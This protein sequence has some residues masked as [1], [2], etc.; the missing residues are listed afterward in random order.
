MPVVA[1]STPVA[2]STL[3]KGARIALKYRTP[4]FVLSD[5]YLA[6]GSGPWLL[7]D[8]ESLPEISVDFVEQP[9]VDGGFMPY[10]R[11]PETLARQWAIQERPGSSTDRRAREGGRDRQR[12]L[13]PRQP[14]P[15]G[16]PARAEGGRDRR[17]HSRA[18]GRRPRRGVAARPGLG[19]DVR[20]PIQSAAQRL[21]K[22]GKQ[23]AH[24]HLTHLNPFPRNLGEVL[25]R[26]DR[27]L[28]PEMN[29]GQLLKLIRAEFLVDAVGYNRVRGSRSARMSS[30]RRSRRCS[31][32]RKL[33]ERL[34]GSSRAGRHGARHDAS[35]RL[36]RAR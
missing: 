9:N 6:N 34:R 27:V 31:V 21:R 8:V 28:V 4:V 14:R 3:R 13:R 35:G 32:F 7:P 23:V 17:R 19:R 24:A 33:L 15:H 22:D 26:Y 29:L 1:A 16:S 10:Q 20:G 18:R 5:A 25:G 12:L 36:R 2:A 30:P 11:D